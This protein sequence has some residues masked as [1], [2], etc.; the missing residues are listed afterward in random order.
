MLKRIVIFLI[1]GLLCIPAVI[2][3]CGQDKNIEI[4]PAPVFAETS[5]AKQSVIQAAVNFTLTT[6]PKAGTFFSVYPNNTDVTEHGTVGA[7]WVSGS[8]AVQIRAFVQAAGV[9]AGTY[10]VSATE[11]GKSESTRVALTVTEYIEPGN[12]CD[13][14]E[15]CDNNCDCD[16]NCGCE[17]NSGSGDKC[18]CDGMCD[19]DCDCDENCDCEC[20]KCKCDGVCKDN[21]DCDENCAC[22]CNIVPDICCHTMPAWRGFNKLNFFYSP[23]PSPS[24]DDGGEPIRESD[25]ALMQQMGFNFVRYPAD[26]RYF[27]NPVNQQFNEEKLK[28]LDD[29]IRLGEKYGIHTKIN[30]HTAP[31]FSVIY[32]YGNSPDGLDILTDGKEHFIRIWQ[33]LANRYKDK[34]NTVVSFNIVNEPCAAGMVF[35]WPGTSLGTP[36]IELLRETINA[37]RVISPNRLIVLDADMRVPI[38]LN[39]LGIPVKNLVQ[40]PHNYA[41][42]SVTHW[43]MEGTND[44]PA[45]YFP[46]RQITWPITN[47]FNGMLFGPGKSRQFFGDAPAKARINLPSGFSPRNLRIRIHE[48]SGNN[49]LT[50]AWGT[51]TA[52]TGTATRSVPSNTAAGT[53]LEFA[54][55]VIPINATWLELWMS[56][57]DDDWIRFDQI[58]IVA[59]N[60]ANNITINATNNDWGFPP[61]KITIGLDTIT[62]AAT[63]KD[64]ILPSPKWDNVPVIIGEMGCMASNA[65]EATYRAALMKDYVDAFGDMPWAFWEFK[66]GHMSLFRMGIDMNDVYNTQISVQYTPDGGTLQK[67]DYRYDGRW[68]EAIK[69]KLDLPENK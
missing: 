53:F 18:K 38:D 33:E 22:D 43:G 59:S 31:G 30:L 35:P 8:A 54:T 2:I 45:G 64:W 1:I 25:Y 21:C 47:Y 24:Y 68:Y 14:D 57:A 4:T 13:C 26:Y 6:I 46:G 11:P 20:N 34:P 63:I 44:F 23:S 10:W 36:Y 7:L 55:D 56:G 51:G 5:I 66:G 58:I 32:G 39:L 60:T 16:E 48:S 52:Q 27:Y 9:P 19:A 69:H 65:T 3:S 37:I 29:A 42:K 62:N 50:L 28:Q 17:C 12:G 41:P 40:S 49:T 15:D 67:E 61:S